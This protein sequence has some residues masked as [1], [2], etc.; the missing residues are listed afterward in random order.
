[1]NAVTNKTA[2]KPHSAV[3][4]VASLIGIAPGAYH[5]RDEAHPRRNAIIWA[6]RMVYYIGYN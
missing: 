2:R 6:V 3:P 1:M 4:M 5:N